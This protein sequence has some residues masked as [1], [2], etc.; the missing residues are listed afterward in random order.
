MMSTTGVN[1]E[2]FDSETAPPE[3]VPDWIFWAN[4]AP[5]PSEPAGN[6]LTKISPLVAVSTLSLNFAC[7][8][9]YLT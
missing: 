1:G 4:A 6:N 3:T 7:I 8:T 5:I 2:K 9:G